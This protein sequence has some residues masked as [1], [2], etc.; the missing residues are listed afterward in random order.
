MFSPFLLRV[1]SI[2][3]HPIHLRLKGFPLIIVPAHPDPEIL[4]ILFIVSI[5]VPNTSSRFPYAIPH[6]D[7]KLK[8]G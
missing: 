8:K 1:L 6:L 4:S 5:L 7:L 3:V 2:C